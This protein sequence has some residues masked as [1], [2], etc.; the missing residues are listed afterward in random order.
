MTMRKKREYNYDIE[1]IYN[2]D[3]DALDLKKILD[4]LF[5][6]FLMEYELQKILE[7]EDFLMKL[8]LLWCIISLLENL[9]YF[10]EGRKYEQNI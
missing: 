1:Y 9:H 5:K 10:V 4:R 7:N 8:Y 2:K 6:K 3:K